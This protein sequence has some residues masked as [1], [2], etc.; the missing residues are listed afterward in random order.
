MAKQEKNPAQMPEVEPASANKFH[1][2]ATRNEFY[3]GLIAM[4]KANTFITR[5]EVTCEVV[6]ENAIEAVYT[7]DGETAAYALINPSRTALD[8]TLPEG[9]WGV[10]ML[11]ETVA[12]EPT[13][14]ISGT[15]HVEGRTVLLVKAE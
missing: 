13:E 3:R 12:A 2:K 9:Q 1:F 5:G 8:W 6:R 10:L 14:T 15:V 4:R 11:N 7:L